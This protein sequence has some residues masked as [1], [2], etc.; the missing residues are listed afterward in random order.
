MY[1]PLVS[2]CVLAAV[3]V[4]AVY[5]ILDMITTLRKRLLDISHTAQLAEY[6]TGYPY[7]TGLETKPLAIEYPG[8]LYKFNASIAKPNPLKK[9]E[10][11]NQH[12]RTR[13]Q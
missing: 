11:R 4:I 9:I 2:F 5:T 10:V 7:Y 6:H 3:I 8:W 13:A 12:G 1:F